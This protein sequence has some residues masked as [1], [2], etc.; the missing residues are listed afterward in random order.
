MYKD[1]D[2]LAIHDVREIAPAAWEPTADSD[3]RTALEAW[4]IA[5][6]ANLNDRLDLEAETRQSSRRTRFSFLTHLYTVPTRMQN[7]IDQHHAQQATIDHSL[8]LN[9]A[10]EIR[11]TDH[12]HAWYRA[13][14][15]AG[16]DPVDWLQWYQD[17]INQW[18]NNDMATRTQ[19]QIDNT[20]FR[21]EFATLPHYWLT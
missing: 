19:A 14:L 13:G 9:L 1:A 15:A 7:L 11:D 20:A 10:T 18:E 5:S 4:Y 21:A 3:W 2:E 12:L 8:T 16:G 17:R 6:L